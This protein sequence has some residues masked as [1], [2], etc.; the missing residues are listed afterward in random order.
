MKEDLVYFV[1]GEHVGVSAFLQE[2]GDT[3]QRNA[4][5]VSV[6]L[7]V[8]L[9]YGRLGRS[10][11]HA[12][13]LRA[14]AKHVVSDPSKTE[15]LE[16]FWD[17]HKLAEASGKSRMPSSP[18]RIRP[19]SSSKSKRRRSRALSDSTGD[20]SGEPSL[21]ADHPALS[22]LALLDTFGP[23]FF[24]LYRAA[25]ARKRILIVDTLPVQ[26]TCNYGMYLV[27]ICAW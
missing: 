1:H 6:G 14:L 18:E 7:L 9:S 26:R 15:P 3:S 16:E 12:Q 23:L 13:T 24:P 21:T 19:S 2:E 5:F 8:P 22:M 20:V 10:W 25:L 17:A 4:R 27:E 11:L